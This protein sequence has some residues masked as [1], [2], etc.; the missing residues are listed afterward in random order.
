MCLSSCRFFFI[1]WYNG[2]TSGSSF[3]ACYL[4]TPHSGVSS[5]LLAGEKEE[6]DELVWCINSCEFCFWQFALFLVAFE[7]FRDS[8]FWPV[9]RSVAVFLEDTVSLTSMLMTPWVHSIPSSN[10]KR[11]FPFF[12]LSKNNACFRFWILWLKF[13]YASIAAE[14]FLNFFID[15]FAGKRGRKI[16]RNKEAAFFTRLLHRI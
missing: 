6:F 11:F 10:K 3:W 5:A 4:F 8:G 16:A 12:L 9:G 15:S 2:P 14:N 7:S 13:E 1:F